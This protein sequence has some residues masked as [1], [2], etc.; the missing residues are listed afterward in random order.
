M[1]VTIRPGNP[2]DTERVTELR[3]A[4]SLYE[5]QYADGPFVPDEGPHP[6][7]V[8]LA[9]DVVIGYLDGSWT[10][11]TALAHL[12][13]LYVIPQYRGMGIGRSLVD[14]FATLA[15]AEGA[16]RVSVLCLTKNRPARAFYKAQGFIFLKQ[17]G[18]LG[19]HVLSL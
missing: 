18:A 17:V 7:L 19:H 3:A 12:N 10:V 11:D 5:S 4:L 14:V 16:T 6:L 1:K 2:A 15:K 8:S 13:Q 9:D